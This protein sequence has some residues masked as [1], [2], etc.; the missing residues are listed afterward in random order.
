MHNLDIIPLRAA[1]GGAFMLIALSRTRSA[2]LVPG[3]PVSRQP[4]RRLR[5]LLVVTVVTVCVTHMQG[6]Y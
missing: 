6:T 4:N 3:I 1:F 5:L 2:L